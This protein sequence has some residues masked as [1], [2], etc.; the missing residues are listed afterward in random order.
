MTEMGRAYSH[1][2]MSIASALETAKPDERL[3]GLF[4]Q[5]SPLLESKADRTEALL[6]EQEMTTAEAVEGFHR[7][8]RGES[9]TSTPCTTADLLRALRVRGLGRRHARAIGR[10]VVGGDLAAPALGTK[11]VHCG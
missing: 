9:W 6:D 7:I 10:R 1:L 8:A 11:S 5:I 3:R 4:A 2:L